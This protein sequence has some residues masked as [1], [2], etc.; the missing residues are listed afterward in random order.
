MRTQYLKALSK[1]NWL[2][3]LSLET[4]HCG[5]SF[6]TESNSIGDVWLDLIFAG[7][8]YAPCYMC[9]VDCFTWEV[10][11]DWEILVLAWRAGPGRGRAGPRP[12]VESFLL[13]QFLLCCI[14]RFQNTLYTLYSAH[15]IIVQKSLSA[16]QNSIKAF[17]LRSGHFQNIFLTEIF[18]AVTGIIFAE[19]FH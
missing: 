9:G 13:R 17:Q 5:E 12:L 4:F 16:Y 18:S 15:W 2:N 10:R 11:L 1:L 7:H 19:Y 8:L 3:H 6:N 14:Y